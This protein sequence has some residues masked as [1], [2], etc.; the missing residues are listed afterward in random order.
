MRPKK[1]ASVETTNELSPE[2]VTTIF[3]SIAD[4]V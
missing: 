2:Q 3:D 1:V 4:G